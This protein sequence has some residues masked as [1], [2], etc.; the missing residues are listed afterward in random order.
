MHRRYSGFR[1]P[2]GLRFL[3][4]SAFCAASRAALRTPNG[5]AENRREPEGDQ[6]TLADFGAREVAEAH[7]SSHRVERNMELSRGV[8]EDKPVFCGPARWCR[9][10]F[11]RLQMNDLNA[12]L[13]G[14]CM[15]STHLRMFTQT[16]VCTAIALTGVKFQ[17]GPKYH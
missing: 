3:A 5:F 7:P 2:A 11:N 10:S 15:D 4:G 17:R 1:F 6:V 12:L 16:I 13:D 9:F 8:F 14:V